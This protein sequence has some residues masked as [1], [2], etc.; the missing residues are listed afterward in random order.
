MDDQIITSLL[1]LFRSSPP[2]PPSPFIFHEND[3]Q[4]QHVFPV[5]LISNKIYYKCYEEK[6]LIQTE[7]KTTTVEGVNFR[8]LAQFPCLL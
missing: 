6:T 5:K 4:T 1:T 8:T 3:S 2:P 7:S